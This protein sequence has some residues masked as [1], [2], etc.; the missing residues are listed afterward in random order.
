MLSLMTDLEATLP[1]QEQPSSWRGRV[2]DAVLVTA[3]LAVGGLTGAATAPSIRG[4]Y[5][6]LQRPSWNPPDQVFGPVWTTLYATM[7]VALR[8]VAR[9]PGRERAR[10]IAVGLF[11][12]QLALNAGWSWLFFI[13]HDLALAAVEVACLW[14][15]I[16]ATIAAFG[17]VRPRAGL[18]LVPYLGWV[19]FASVLTLAIWRLNR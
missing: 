8:D 3:P 13:Q 17:R 16:A 18:L 19:S 5:R 12:L 2:V 4:W 6:T 1:V 15:A 14:L 7:G 9:A 10:A 11:G